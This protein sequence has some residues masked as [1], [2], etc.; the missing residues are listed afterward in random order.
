MEGDIVLLLWVDV[1][2]GGDGIGCLCRGGGVGRVGIAVGVAI[3]SPDAR[4]RLPISA[5][6]RPLMVAASIVGSTAAC[7]QELVASPRWPARP[8]GDVALLLVTI[9]AVL[10]GKV[11]ASEDA[12]RGPMRPAE[13]APAAE[14]S[15]RRSCV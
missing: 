6:D 8:Q 2:V 9:L 13:E 12:A 4:S 7:I 11:I 14:A 5:V 15:A 3:P 1:S 10:I